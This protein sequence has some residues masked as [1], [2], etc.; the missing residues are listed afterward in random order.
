MGRMRL[1]TGILCPGQRVH[2]Y[3]LNDTDHT[4]V[5]VRERKRSNQMS[6][7]V[8][9]HKKINMIPQ[10]NYKVLLVG[11]YRGHVYGDCFDDAG[12]NISEKNAN[13]CELTGV[14]WLW[15]NLQKDDYVGIVHYR[16][17]FSR[18]F[19][20]SKKLSDKDIRKL[21]GKYDIILPFKQ[22]MEPNVL[23]QFCQISGLKK[24]MDRVRGII[25]RQCPDYLRSFDSVMTDT[26]AYLFNM[27]ICSREKFNAYCQWLFSIFD[28][29]EPMVDLSEYNDYQKR[30]YGFISERLLNVW[31]R[32]NELKVCELGVVNTEE[33]WSA[34]K[35]FLTACKRV[36]LYHLR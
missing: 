31:V 35:N 1:L 5:T 11:A 17:L 19:S 27:M 6:V 30:I 22:K 36:L 15:K 2:F 7:Y 26:E 28:E 8:I 18:S 34:G 16:R 9:T 20:K 23:E 32:Q 12:D 13:Y 21:L 24:D 14:Y 3:T 33:D 10:E 29:L 25:E 4:D